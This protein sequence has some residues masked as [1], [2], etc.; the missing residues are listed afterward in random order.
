MPSWQ[1]SCC[2]RFITNKWQTKIWIVH[3]GYTSHVRGLEYFPFS[4]LSLSRFYSLQSPNTHICLYLINI[5]NDS[6]WVPLHPTTEV[7]CGFLPYGEAITNVPLLSTM[8]NYFQLTFSLHQNITRQAM[9]R[10]LADRADDLKACNRSQLSKMRNGPWTL[11]CGVCDYADYH[12]LIQ[13]PGFLRSLVH[14]S[15]INTIAVF[16]NL[17]AAFRN[18]AILKE[19]ILVKLVRELGRALSDGYHGASYIPDQ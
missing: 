12:V 15:L 4:R 6:S 18:M 16:S 10:W 1:I 11:T 17:L 8:R 13:L 9:V 7:K 14:L 5:C 19:E 3:R 2:E